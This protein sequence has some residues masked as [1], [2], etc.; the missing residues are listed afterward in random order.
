MQH[1]SILPYIL[2]MY[3]FMNIYFVCFKI[4]YKIQNPLWNMIRYKM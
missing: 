3:L 2:K 1:V 4:R